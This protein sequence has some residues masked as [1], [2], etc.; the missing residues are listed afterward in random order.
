MARRLSGGG[1]SKGLLCVAAAA[2]LLCFFAAGSY[3]R[4]RVCRVPRSPVSSFILCDAPPIIC[5]SRWAMHHHHH[6]Q[7]F[8]L[9]GMHKRNGLIAGWL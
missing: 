1:P 4:D 5:D 6:E 8:D 3:K 9:V 2:P 7:I